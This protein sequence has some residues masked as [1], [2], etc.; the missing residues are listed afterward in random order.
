MKIFK[1]EEPKLVKIKEDR[2]FTSDNEVNNED[3]EA[4]LER[5]NFILPN[6]LGR[7][8]IY[9]ALLPYRYNGG[10]SCKP[11]PVMVIE[12]FDLNY[13][14]FAEQ[15]GN[16]NNDSNKE[17]SFENK[18]TPTE[19]TMESKE[20]NVKEK[21]PNYISKVFNVWLPHVPS[22]YNSFRRGKE[23]MVLVYVL[24]TTLID[25]LCTGLDAQYKP[26][27]PTNKFPLPYFQ[28]D[29]LR[30]FGYIELFKNVETFNGL[31][32]AFAPLLISKRTIYSNAGPN[33]S[34]AYLQ[35]VDR[36]L[37]SRMIVNKDNWEK[38]ELNSV[39]KGRIQPVGKCLI[40]P[41]DFANGG[42]EKDS[43]YREKETITY[44]RSPLRL[45]EGEPKQVTV[46]IP[47]I[48][49][50]KRSIIFAK[51]RKLMLEEE[52]LF[53]CWPDDC[54]G[55][56]KEATDYDKEGNPDISSSNPMV[57]K[58]RYIRKVLFYKPSLSEFMTYQKLH[59]IPSNK[60]YSDLNEKKVEFIRDTQEKV[61]NK[62]KLIFSYVYSAEK[63]R[64]CRFYGN[65]RIMA[66]IPEDWE[67]EAREEEKKRKEE[68][69]RKRREEEERKKR[70]EEERKRKEEE[71]K[72]KREIKRTPDGKVMVNLKPKKKQ[73][74]KVKSNPNKE[75]NKEDFI[76][77]ENPIE[78]E[79][80]EESKEYSLSELKDFLESF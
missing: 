21:E 49:D 10:K 14:A 28:R 73:I 47:K 80:V 42:F 46:T 50:L 31:S 33:N 53:P 43:S 67:I 41:M 78:N 66:W 12:D 74:V 39:L 63:G 24:T 55:E 20:S 72:R 13:D 56:I 79:K 51:Y 36:L 69:E 17:S 22:F 23:P 11:H 37:F 76:S 32:K 5:E 30:K 27:A 64:E 54:W 44:V 77:T 58:S 35:S 9:F 61:N 75:E 8:D 19:S 7:G 57:N 34:K 18:G 68:E 1:Y 4:F 65:P 38:E 6:N 26:I 62:P 60:E 71:E 29:N 48:E 25:S 2:Q 52:D 59:Y 45:R 40:E 15:L 3:V 16:S 70:E